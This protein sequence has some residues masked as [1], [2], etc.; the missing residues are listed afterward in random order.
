[1]GYCVAI[2]DPYK[3]GDI[4]ASLADPARGRHSIQIEINRAL[5]MDEITRVANDGFDRLQR[6]IG[7]VTARLAGFDWAAL[8]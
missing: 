7:T 2:N 4:V 1:M 6:D 5:Y 3:G 8:R